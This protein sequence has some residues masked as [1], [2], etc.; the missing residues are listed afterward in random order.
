MDTIRDGIP[1]FLL[2]LLL[3]AAGS[4]Y[5]A[6]APSPSG[7]ISLSHNV[8]LVHER[9]PHA[10]TATMTFAN[11]TAQWLTLNTEVTG[12]VHSAQ[13]VPHFLTEPATALSWVHITPA[14]FRIAPGDSQT[15]RV[16][17]TPPSSW[18]V[19][20]VYAGLLVVPVVT[21]RTGGVGLNFGLSGQVALQIG[22][23]G[24][25]ALRL[26][27]RPV[28]WIIWGASPS[29]L[30]LHLAN[31]G[32]TVLS[33]VLSLQMLDHG[34]LMARTEAFLGYLPPGVSTTMG[35]TVAPL[36]PGIDQAV[37]TLS[38]P[39]LPHP[40]TWTGW[41][42]RFPVGLAEAMVGAV[43]AVELVRRLAARRHRSHPPAPPYDSGAGTPRTRRARR[44]Q[45]QSLALQEV[46]SAPLT[47]SRVER[48]GRKRRRVRAVS[49]A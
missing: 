2:V 6:A 4:G 38:A 20:T 40:I 22:P 14:H 31:T 5:A 1:R 41:V 36:P 39:G 18:R 33:P 46:L 48:Y 27:N 30:F 35:A 11:H 7:G 47:P 49:S 43:A 12:L 45:R 13:N 15:L 25:G 9:T 24:V 34:Q 29:Q 21:P 3:L 17:L 19:T 32:H 37:V 28:P 23:R 16:V 10:T 44:R 26:L 42:V 8:F